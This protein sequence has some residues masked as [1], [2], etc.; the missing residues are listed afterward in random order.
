MKSIYVKKTLQFMERA[1]DVL[2]LILPSALA[3]FGVVVISL[4]LLGE[5]R[6]EYAWPLGL[7]V[8]IGVSIPIVQARKLP[9]VARN[10]LLVCNAL[11]LMGAL[12]WIGFNSFYTSQHL[13]TN[14]DPGVYAVTATWLTKQNNLELKSSDSFGEVAGV[15]SFS[16]GFST[17]PRDDS[18]VA[19]QGAH[20][21]SGLLG[22]G[23]R[24][25]GNVHMFRLSV[26]FGG[27]ALIA[28]YGFARQL[29]KPIWALVVV[30][31]VA[32]S[33]PLIYFSR[34]TY[35]EPLAATFTFGGLAL[36]IEAQ[37]R[38]K[39]LSWLIA[40]LVVGAGALT[41]ID[42]YLVIAA[43]SAFIVILLSLS[44][45][46][47][48]KSSL[49]ASGL[50]I[51]GMSIPAILGYLDIWQLSYS[52]FLSEWKNIKPELIAIAAIFVVGVPVIIV[53][54]YTPVLKRLDK[55]TKSWR[56]QAIAAAIL[57]VSLVLLSRPLWYTSY[58]AR[59]T[60]VNGTIE[61]IVQR[62]FAEITIQW[63][64]W[65]IGPILTLLSGFG[66]ALA[67]RRLFQKK[68]L[69]LLAPLITIGGTAL[70]YLVNPSIFPDQVWASRRLLP[71]ILPGIAFFGVFTLQWLY[72]KQRFMGKKVPG[73]IVA[74]SLATLAVVSPLFTTLPFI[75]TREATWHAPLA[76][77]CSS[78]PP[79]AA[80]LW[81]GTARTQLVEPTKAVCGL[82]SAGYGVLFGGDSKIDQ[83]VLAKVAKNAMQRGY[84]PIV[85]SF[86]NETH[87]IEAEGSN[88]LAP[89][90]SF[91]YKLIEQT[92]TRPP[93]NTNTYN[94]TI[95][96][97]IIEKDGVVRP[98][99][100]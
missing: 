32:L 98:L 93:M 26:V 79:N 44:P 82:S 65:Y 13:F 89:V 85:G 30:G 66:M 16:G 72:K 38:K 77:L 1:L 100:N 27:L 91:S 64:M 25:V 46:Q 95:V 7:I 4:L 57:I 87:L 55:L 33:L 39:A 34:D 5:L 78:L 53:S 58:V 23:G 47:D 61:Q 36:V 59:S 54:W 29:M 50:F 24:I 92:H 9:K 8:S 51:T 99:T 94:N 42:A 52:Y 67:T 17:D 76:S 81:I 37:K 31:A 71:V 45:K 86:G 48:R 35:T 2:P 56:L 22:L 18:Q 84:Q 11:V 3:G 60:I 68:D 40:G 15:E 83:E 63:L 69:K 21:F 73:N 19:A 75:F 20:L 70:F 12:L 74:T 41:R 14:R 80:V 10:E 43:L 96:V 49:V 6:S 90:S 97:G 88:S 62:D 28:I